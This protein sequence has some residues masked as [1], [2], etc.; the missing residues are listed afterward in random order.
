MRRILII[1]ALLLLPGICLVAQQ[2]P[3][4]VTPQLIAPYTLQVSEY[5]SPGA[6]G[7]KLNLL[8]LLRDF[9]KPSLQVRLRMSITSQTVAIT[10]KEEA[11][12]TPVTIQSGEPRYLDPSELAQYFNANNLNF[13]GITRTQ[14]EQ[15]G[16][17]PEGFYTFC[18][19]VVEVGT[20][21][22]VSNKGCTIAWLTLNEPPLLNMPRK[23][24][25]VIPPANGAPQNVL[26]QW[27]P[28][29]TASPTAYNTDYIISIIELPDNF[30]TPE[31]AFSSY[32]PNYVDSTSLT[33]YLLD[34]SKPFTFQVGYRYAWRVQVKAKNGTQELAMFRNNG[35]SETF[36]F[37]YK[38]NCPAPS[39]IVADPQGQRVNVT[40]LSDVKHLDYKVEYRQK[41]NPDAEWFEL[42]NTLP[43]VSI[44]DLKDTTTYEYRVGG[45]C[46]T[47]VYTF[48][49]LNEFTTRSA[50]TTTVPNCGFVPDTSIT[51]AQ[52]LQQM[53]PGD[54][55]KAG[56][57]DVIATQVSGSGSFSGQGYVVVPWLANM[58]LGVS[59][60]SI[61][62]GINKKL[63]IG[64]ISTTYDPE[65]GLVGDVDET[66]EALDTI[67]S[68]F[69]AKIK[70]L[71][72]V[73]HS[74]DVTEDPQKIVNYAYNVISSVSDEIPKQILDDIIQKTKALEAAKDALASAGT[75]I[76]KGQA[77]ENLRTAADNL[78]N[79]W[80]D[81]LQLYASILKDAVKKYYDE[82]KPQ[83]ATIIANYQNLLTSVNQNNTPAASD[84]DIIIH[85]IVTI[86][87]VSTDGMDPA[88]LALVTNFSNA[89]KEYVMYQ[90]AKILTEEGDKGGMMDKFIEKAKLLT[91]DFTNEIKRDLENKDSKEVIIDK[92]KAMVVDA[93]GKIIEDIIK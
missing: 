33:T 34:N 32:E 40:W 14:Y 87:S 51:N 73:L 12:Y 67:V 35:Y 23:A 86:D 28:R 21:Q 38:N 31:T 6:S 3:V 59:F 54:T 5:Y 82:K 55:I 63:K 16:K 24:E 52:L 22:V 25:S 65:E 48:S 26:F 77:E 76:E 84:D 13:S 27:T 41:G 46:E 9:N 90:F 20:N 78:S 75:E 44:T 36:W 30:L 43:R 85:E 58:K 61:G 53:N 19:E 81:F 88:T 49:G 60:E 89:E 1:A 7:S 39:G 64:E 57:F 15:T 45:A 70:S 37:I 68:A 10:T 62:V 72:Q 50:N 18:F 29:H 17:L 42:D 80:N 93:F 74:D 56:D 2:F 83:E 8:L 66:I 92:V 4:Q 11:V 79:S 47:G 91:V 71:I 69:T